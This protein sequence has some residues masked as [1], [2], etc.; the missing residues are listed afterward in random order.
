M[1]DKWQNRVI[2][3][4]SWME[5]SYQSYLFWRR[6]KMMQ[7]N[8]TLA[9]LKANI[10][11]KLHHVTEYHRDQ[12]E[13]EMLERMISQG[14]IPRDDYNKEERKLLIKAFFAFMYGQKG[15]S[16]RETAHEFDLVLQEIL[17]NRCTTNLPPEKNAHDLYIAG[18]LPFENKCD[19]K[20]F[21]SYPGHSERY[22]YKDLTFKPDLKTEIDK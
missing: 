4:E 3:F 7:E 12:E 20:C 6:H 5:S 14:M 16:T 1:K 17:S 9:R 15:D 13:H 18:Q 8:D 11:V 2:E 10:D 21:L 19:I 22:K